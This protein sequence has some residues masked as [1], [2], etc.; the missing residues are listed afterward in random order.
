MA[1]QSIPDRITLNQLADLGTF[2]PPQDFQFEEEFEHS[3][4]RPIPAELHD[5]RY[6]TKRRRSAAI[7]CVIGFCCMLLSFI[8]GIQQLAPSIPLFGWLLWIG[9]A[10]VLIGAGINFSSLFSKGNYRYVEHGTPLALRIRAIWAQ[11]SIV[12][13]GQPTQYQF[14]TVVDFLHPETNELTIGQLQSDGLT[15][16][17]YKKVKTTYRVGDYVTGV[18]LPNRS[19]SSLCLY[20]FLGLRPGLGIEEVTRPKGIFEVIAN[21]VIFCLFMSVLILSAVALSMYH[22]IDMSKSSIVAISV[23]AGALLGTLVT[24]WFVFHMKRENAARAIRNQ[25]AIESGEAS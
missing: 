16:S 7:S 14:R 1:S 4:P 11:P 6:E 2:N 13:Y 5:G 3:V 12:Q 8:P 21:T 22:P 17:E 15:T 19:L 10:L 25:G 23:T 24:V 9:A 18:F 20:G